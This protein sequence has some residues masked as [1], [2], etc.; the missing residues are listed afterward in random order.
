MKKQAKHEDK[1]IK[2]VDSKQNAEEKKRLEEEK[3]YEN[4]NDEC[5]KIIREQVLVLFENSKLDKG[6]KLY[7]FAFHLT[8]ELI[9]DQIPLGTFQR[10]INHGVKEAQQNYLE[11]LDKEYYIKP[12]IVEEINNKNT[13]N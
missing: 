13:L 6:L 2:L 7:N 11:M 5:K 8:Q 12:K 9:Y 10:A 1:L 3:N 4:F